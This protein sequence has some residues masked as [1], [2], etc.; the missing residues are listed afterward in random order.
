MKI[1]IPGGSGHLGTALTGSLRRAGHSVVIL[2]RNVESPGLLWDGRTLGGWAEAVDGA[3]V[4]INLAGRSVELPLR[5]AATPG[6]P[7]LPRRL[8]AGD[9]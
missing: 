2:S 1:V 6:D 8:D 5:A 3:D 9:R 4:V 7:P